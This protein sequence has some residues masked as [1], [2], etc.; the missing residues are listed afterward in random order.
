MLKHFLEIIKKYIFEHQYGFQKMKSTV[1]A[2]LDLLHNVVDTFE[3]ISYSAV[4]FL[5]FAKAFDTVNH[6]ILIDKLYGVR[7]M[8]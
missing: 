1:M 7:G 6:D 5:D 8:V 2:V 4:I 3:N